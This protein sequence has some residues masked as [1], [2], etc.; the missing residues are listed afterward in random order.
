MN[1]VAYIVAVVRQAREQR[2]QKIASIA[3]A[4]R[5][6]VRPSAQAIPN[7]LPVIRAPIKAQSS[8]VARPAVR[9]T[10][11]MQQFLQQLRR[12]NNLAVLAGAG[13]AGGYGLY[14]YF[15]RPQPQQ[16]TQ[17]QGDGAEAIKQAL[18]FRQSFTD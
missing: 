15:N 5:R 9:R 16:E 6:V 12:P 3:S 14:R 8:S 1:K 17:E 4:A 2:L 11:T 18:R 13:G 7:R 10:T